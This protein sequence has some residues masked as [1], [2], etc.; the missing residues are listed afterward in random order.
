MLTG[1]MALSAIAIVTPS[2]MA[3]HY[4]G[5][6]H[7]IDNDHVVYHHKE[8]GERRYRITKKTTYVDHHGNVVE[9]TKITPKTR[10]RI[11]YSTD[12][13]RAGHHLADRIELLPH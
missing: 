3:D 7:S 12:P 10:T 2:A 13:E 8:H 6:V 4:D 11:H 1:A 5:E 9:R